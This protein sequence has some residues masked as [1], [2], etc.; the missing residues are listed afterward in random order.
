MFGS[1]SWWFHTGVQYPRWT[2]MIPVSSNVIG[3]GVRLTP[4]AF[5]SLSTLLLKFRVFSQ[6][7]KQKSRYM[8][9]RK[10]LWRLLFSGEWFCLIFLYLAGIRS[11]KLMQHVP[12]KRQHNSTRLHGFRFQEILLIVNAIENFK[13]R[14]NVGYLKLDISMYSLRIKQLRR[15][16]SVQGK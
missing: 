2:Y 9:S 7:L 3:Y 8:M 6:L 16:T 13:F 11:W 4:Y 5:L 14:V 10:W 12:P 1:I 15:K